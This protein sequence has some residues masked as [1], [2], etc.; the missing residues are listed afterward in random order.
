E[1]KL[2]FYGITDIVERVLEENPFK[3]AKRFEDYL[4][5]DAWARERAKALL[6]QN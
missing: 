3:N 4:E 2:S 1:G 6:P 5:A